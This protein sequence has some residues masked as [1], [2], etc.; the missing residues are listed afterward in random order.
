MERV[1]RI[2]EERYAK[3]E[4]ENKRREELI[5]NNSEHAEKRIAEQAIEGQSVKPSQ[6]SLKSALTGLPLRSDMP[7]ARGGPT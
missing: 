1:T 3:A 5:E 2:H 4:A 6:E 7:T